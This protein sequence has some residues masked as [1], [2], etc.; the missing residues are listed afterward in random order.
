MK[1]PPSIALGAA[2]L[3][4]TTFAQRNEPTPE[5]EL[6]AK[7]ASPFLKHASWEMDYDKAIATAKKEGKLIFGYF[8]TAGY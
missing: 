3:C 5:Q 7:L 4:S 8:T 1:L 6:E 2:L